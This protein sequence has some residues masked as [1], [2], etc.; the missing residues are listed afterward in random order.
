[1]TL[2]SSERSWKRKGIVGATKTL[3]DKLLIQQGGVCAICGNPPRKRKL[4]LDHDH[5]TGHIRGILC[6]R[7]NYGLSWFEWFNKTADRLERTLQYLQGH[8]IAIPVV[9]DEEEPTP[10]TS[11]RARKG[12]G[13]SQRPN[14]AA[15]RQRIVEE[16]VKL[17]DEGCELREAVSQAAAKHGTNVATVKRYL[18]DLGMGLKTFPSLYIRKRKS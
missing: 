13:Y 16:V 2:S 18:N 10:T 14:V 6:F 11:R 9:A 8:L 17:H 1:M 7:C 5:Q 12:K 15:K 3:Y 4:A